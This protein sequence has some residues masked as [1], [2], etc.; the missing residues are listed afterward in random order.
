MRQN[1]SQDGSDKN[2]QVQQVLL[3]SGGTMVLTLG[4]VEY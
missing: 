3:C 1:S 4:Y 2:G